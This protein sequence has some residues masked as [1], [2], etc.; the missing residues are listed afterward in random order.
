MPLRKSKGIKTQACVKKGEP[1]NDTVASDSGA[2]G[3]AP[4]DG[5]T[6]PLMRTPNF[7]VEMLIHLHRNR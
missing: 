2:T 5:K 1:A 7:R 6:S 4:G 3:E